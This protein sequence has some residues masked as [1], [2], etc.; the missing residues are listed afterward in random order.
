MMF[1]KLHQLSK[2]GSKCQQHMG[3]GGKH[4]GIHVHVYGT[5]FFF[6]SVLLDSSS[7]INRRDTFFFSPS[8]LIN[9]A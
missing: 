9:M 2:K 1:I 5:S 6:F 4:V 7:G 8:C 3:K